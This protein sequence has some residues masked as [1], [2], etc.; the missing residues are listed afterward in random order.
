M[1]NNLQRDDFTLEVA[2]IE[3]CVRGQRRAALASSAHK[4]AS[5]EV[6]NSINLGRALY[7]MSEVSCS[8]ALTHTQGARTAIR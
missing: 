1:L 6:C 4:S 2:V 3:R 5:C 7:N 8:R